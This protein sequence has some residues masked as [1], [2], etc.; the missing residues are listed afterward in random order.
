MGNLFAAIIAVEAYQDPFLKR[1][2][3]AEKDARA[4]SAAL[5]EIGCLIENQTILINDKATQTAIDSDVKS[6]LLGL[7]PEDQCFIFFAGH[8]FSDG[9]HNYLATH[10]T[11]S[12]D[13]EQTSLRLQRLLGFMQQS[14]SKKKVLFLD[15]CHT[16]IQIEDTVRSAV[17]GIVPSEDEK[18]CAGFASCRAEQKSYSSTK[19]EHGI[20]TYHLLE[21]L[22]GRAAKAL[23]GELLTAVKLQAYLAEEVPRTVLAEFAQPKPQ[24]PRFFGSYENI[25]AIADLSTLLAKRRATLATN[26]ISLKGV[27][28]VA[29]SGKRIASL[30]GFDKKKGHFV[31]DRVN[32]ATDRFVKKL[33]VMNCKTILMLSLNKYAVQ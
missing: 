17:A 28:I 25:T 1:V 12:R 33:Q 20:W 11:R 24:T 32:D 7:S 27:A 21:A 10:D 8:G 16:G 15:A 23:D 2:L 18:F 26:A 9:F 22:S 5:A 29:T 14:P 6:L 19:L 13:L 3:Y 4:I 31:Q 30:K